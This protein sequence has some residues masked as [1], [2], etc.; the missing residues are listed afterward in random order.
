MV[1][2]SQSMRKYVISSALVTSLAFTP[3]VS[4]SVFAK[5]DP[6]AADE[7]SSSDSSILSD[8]D[9][10][11]DVKSL[12][13]DLESKGYYTSSLDGIFGP[14]TEAAVEE[15]Q[16][17]NGLS[18]DGLVGQNT[19]NK[20]SGSSE[21]S[22]NDD[23]Q[24]SEDTESDDSSSTEEPTSSEE[25]SS[26]EE[27][28]SAEEDSSVE[29]TTN[30]TSASQSDVVSIAEDQ[31]GTPYVWGGTTPEGFDSSG[32][33]LHV[34]DEVGVDLNRKE[35]DMWLYDGERVESPSIGDVVFF[36]GTY[37]TEG[38][39]HSGVYIGDDQ[40]I[41]SGSNG[42]EVA[43]LNIDYWQDHYLGVKSFQ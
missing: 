28:T 40:M 11:E 34:F 30:E 19:E 27:T 33:I 41:H 4:E 3:V 21:D 20:L 42:V 5:A 26:E 39:S 7:S 43:D 17:D 1:K 15:F 12:Q 18:V 2:S 9:R 36:E 24:S 23:E 35:S 10:G 13:S 25:S 32:F 22:S 6:S 38:A 31:I 16:A 29:E 37:D 8:G 14:L